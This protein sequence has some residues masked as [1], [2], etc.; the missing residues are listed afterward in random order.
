MAWL[1][2]PWGFAAEIDEDTLNKL[3]ALPNVLQ[4]LP[5]YSFDLKDELYEELHLFFKENLSYKNGFVW[6]DLSE[7]DYIY[8]VHGQ[9]YVLKV[10]QRRNQSW[11]A[12]DLHEYKVYNAESSTGDYVGKAADASTQTEDKF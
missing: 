9:E 12:V 7:N 4:V 8:P 2:P 10:T 6:H 5:D 1:R 11:S 3:K